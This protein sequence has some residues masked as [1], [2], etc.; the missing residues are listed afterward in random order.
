M[1]GRPALLRAC[2]VALTLAWLI[3]ANH[4]RAGESAQHFLVAQGEARA[5]LGQVEGHS[6]PTPSGKSRYRHIDNGTESTAYRPVIRNPRTTEFARSPFVEPL[7]A[8]SG[9]PSAV[10]NE[11]SRFLGSRNPTGFAESWCRDFVNM[12]LERT[13]HPLADKSHIAIAALRLGPRVSDPRP[14]DV[15]VMRSHTTFFA[16]WAGHGRFVG[17]GG[18]QHGGHVSKSLFS[19]RSVIAFVRPI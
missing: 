9:A 16:G 3:G 12:I 19:M 4:A 5:D 13:G 10:I 8:I 7:E 6:K 18:N 14:G 1:I 11:A 15:V 17:L 2:V